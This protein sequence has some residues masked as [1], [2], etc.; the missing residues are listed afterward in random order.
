MKRKLFLLCTLVMISLML[1]T[2]I[3]HIIWINQKALPNGSSWT[4]ELFPLLINNIVWL[5]IVPL[6]LLWLSKKEISNKLI[7]LLTITTI[8]QLVTIAYARFASDALDAGILF[9]IVAIPIST[10]LLIFSIK[11]LKNST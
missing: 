8:I 2:N 10:L 1:Y 3:D 4:K 5:C 9:V 11:S 6:I 7:G